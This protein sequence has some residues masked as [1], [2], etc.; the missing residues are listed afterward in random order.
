MAPE[1]GGGGGKVVHDDWDW[2]LA[3]EAV[4]RGTSSLVLAEEEEGDGLGLG[5]GVGVGVGLSGGED[6]LLASVARHVGGV[7][8]AEVQRVQ[9]PA[10][11]LGN[12]FGSV[13]K[14]WDA[15]DARLCLTYPE[16]Y[17][18]GASNLGHVVL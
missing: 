3:E 1:G 15:A 8:M 6:R 11:Y 9:R 13:H 14:G 7:P 2:R 12:E 10:R 16:I 17:E 4:P 18:V 5:L